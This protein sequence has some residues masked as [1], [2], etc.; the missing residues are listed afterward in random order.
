MQYEKQMSLTHRYR[1]QTVYL[2]FY[3]M[4]LTTA[5]LLQ[6]ILL[7][8]AMCLVSVLRLLNWSRTGLITQAH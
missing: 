2:K 8:R 4:K 1:G 3:W 6:Y 7:T 5:Y